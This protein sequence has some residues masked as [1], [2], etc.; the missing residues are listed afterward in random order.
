MQK[1][2]KIIDRAHYFNQPLSSYKALKLHSSG[3]NKMNRPN[4]RLAG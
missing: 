1:K 3:S 4:N 2:R